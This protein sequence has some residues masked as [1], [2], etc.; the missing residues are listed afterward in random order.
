VGVLTSLTGVYTALGEDQIDATNLVINQVNRDGG[1]YVKSLGGCSLL[2]VFYEDE[3][4]DAQTAVAGMTKLIY[5]DD[6][7]FVVGG[8]GTADTTPAENINSAAGVP[9]IITDATGNTL[10]TRTDI[11]TT[12]DFIFG[13]TTSSAIAGMVNFFIQDLKPT[14][15]PN[16]NLTI[17]DF[18]EDNSVG[19]LAT[20]SLVNDTNGRGA[21]IIDTQTAMATE[22]D[23]SSSLLAL[24][25]ANPQVL[26]IQCCADIGAAEISAD[27]DYTQTS[28]P[29]ITQNGETTE[30]YSEL[31]AYL[32]QTH[33]DNIF[34]ETQFPGFAVNYSSSVTNFEG[35]AEL[36][37]GRV[38]GPDAAIQYD[39]VNLFLE[40]I[41][42][43]GSIDH[44]AVIHAL[45]TDTFPAGLI[46][47]TNNV[48]KVTGVNDFIGENLVEQVIY[49]STLNA[50]V[51]YVVWPSADAQRSIN[52]TGIGASTTTTSS[53][54]STTTSTSLLP[55]LNGARATGQNLLIGT[56]VAEQIATDS[57]LSAPVFYAKSSGANQDQ[58]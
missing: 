36:V 25:N 32:S 4:D 52:F 48:I 9:F 7:D 33:D 51:P 27:R 44:N 22:T 13:E 29:L 38:L 46:P 39:A 2:Q 31:S 49:N 11:N 15:A 21:D 6:V 26:D 50:A 28:I 34:V 12:G 17:G 24:T 58:P 20:Q 45:R 53:R 30:Y 41:E 54:T 14:L 37:Y 10:T 56:G 19:Q 43:A 23:V 40:A 55:R 3:G 57:T 42:A 18:V 47:M 16:S 8:V 1:I 5:S 35:Q